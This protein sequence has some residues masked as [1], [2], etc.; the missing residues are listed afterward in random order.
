MGEVLRVKGL[1]GGEVEGK[2]GNRASATCTALGTPDFL[3]ERGNTKA[4]M[5]L[6][7]NLAVHLTYFR[8]LGR[9]SYDP[10]PAAQRTAWPA[11]EGMHGSHR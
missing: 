9:R 5:A 6:T 10:S 3:W 8:Q 11:Y 2:D 4:R 7:L 1:A